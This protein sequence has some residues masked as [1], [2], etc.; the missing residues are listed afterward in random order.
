MELVIVSGKGG[1]G[2]TFISSNTLYYLNEHA[3]IPTVG[4]DADVEAPDLILTLGSSHETEKCFEVYESQKAR[5]DYSKCLGS[6]CLAC[7]GTCMF[8]ALEVVNGKPVVI[9]ENCEG[10]TA[11][12]IVC[13]VGAITYYT[14]LTGRVCLYKVG[15]IHVVSGDLE[16]GERNSGHLVYRVREFARDVCRDLKYKHVIVDAA[17]GTGCPVI[18]SLVGVDKAIIVVEPTPQGIEGALRVRKLTKL[19]NI[20]TYVI[21]NKYDLNEE[22]SR[23]IGDVLD[24]E[25]LGMVPYD[26]AVVEAYA[27]MKPVIVHNPHSKASKHL[28]KILEVIAFSVMGS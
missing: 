16:I 26:H 4:A 6:S 22:L 13:R 12:S 8:K 25:V 14:K 18:S 1:T 3:D 7:I 21:V 5:I 28:L 9:E 24:A 19:M 15:S 23:R 27:N 17:A 10:C 2:K 11:C 20:H